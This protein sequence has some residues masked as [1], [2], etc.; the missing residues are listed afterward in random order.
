MRDDSQFRVP[1]LRSSFTKQPLSNM[2][3]SPG[4]SFGSSDRE[5][6]SRTYASPAADK[7]VRR[8]R[9][10]NNSIGPAFNPNVSSFGRQTLSNTKTAMTTSFGTEERG[11]RPRSESPGPGAYNSMGTL[12]GAPVSNIKN[13]PKS[14]FGTSTR[15]QSAAVF[16]SSRHEKSQFAG[17]VSPGPGAYTSTGSIG[18]MAESN[19]PSSP[20]WR[21]GS[22]GRFVYDYIRRARE[23][24][25]AGTY[26]AGGSIGPQ[27]ES[28][29]VNTAAYSFGGVTR[30]SA[31]KIF[32]SNRHEKHQFSGRGTPGPGGYHAYETT[33]GKQ[34]QSRA[35]TA[36]SANFG[37]S[38]RMGMG[39]SDTPGPGSYYAW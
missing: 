34:A 29:K 21:I 30:D 10:G 27:K 9:G 2:K 36:P 19:R 17:R 7:S 14:A 20:S 13:E 4:Y 38:V 1:S 16:I 11:R 35:Q 37:T 8:S 28:Q 12:G 32:I 3:T 6:Y 5:A 26:E 23:V 15:D 24:P 33:F 25:G 18:K 39:K 22:E 31:S